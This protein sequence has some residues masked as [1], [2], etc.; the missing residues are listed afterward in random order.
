MIHILRPQQSAAV[1]DYDRARASASLRR[2][3]LVIVGRRACLLSLA[4]AQAESGA[5]VRAVRYYGVHPV[6]VCRVVGSVNRCADFD[7]AFLPLAQVDK[8]RWESVNKATIR[9]DAMPAVRLIKFGDRYFVEDGHHRVSVACYQGIEY[10][11][12]EIIEYAA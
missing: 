1:T 3:L 4:E 11:D 2:L 10:I 7:P 6:P 5:T 8:F 12:A 9:G